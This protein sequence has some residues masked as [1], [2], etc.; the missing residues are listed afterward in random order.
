MALF[1]RGKWFNKRIHGVEILA[2]LEVAVQ[3]ETFEVTVEFIYEG[4]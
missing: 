1:T 3:Q 4:D 2:P